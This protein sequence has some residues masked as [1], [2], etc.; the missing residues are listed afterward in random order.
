[1]A[2]SGPVRTG[3]FIAIA[4]I[5]A[6][7]SA[8]AQAPQ[9]DHWKHLP[10][11]TT[12]CFSDDDF[13]AK[14]DAA[15]I[16]INAEIEKQEKINAAAKAKFDAMDMM[17]KAQ[18]MQAFMMKNPQAAAKMFEANDA[19]S[20]AATS[21]ATGLDGNTTRLTAELERLKA[22]FR[23]ALE[24]A[25]KPVRARR[26]ALIEAK[27]V[28]VGEVG[29]PMFTN[30]ADH[31][32]YVKLI[33]EENAAIEKACAQFFG[34]SG[35]FQTWLASWRTEVTEKVITAGA[36]TDV[37]GIQLEAMDLP[38]GNYR[39]TTPLQQ[40]GNYLRQVREVYGVRPNRVRPTVELKK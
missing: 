5:A 22:T 12:A 31:A 16:A 17:E 24:E 13:L 34:A 3:A 28:A 26:S 35:S 1:M 30:A 2:I 19:A 32:Q 20:T 37:V 27:T 6:P 9:R 25:V 39:S 14:L 8:F 36:S 15:T 10:P 38:G 18:R 4:A 29:E 21:A 40:V 7:I 23:S 11:L 33:E